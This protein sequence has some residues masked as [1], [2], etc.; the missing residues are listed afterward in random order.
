MNR[1]RKL[2]NKMADT[3]RKVF[4]DAKKN[5]AELY[6][7]GVLFVAVPAAV[8]LLTSAEWGLLLS[9]VSQ[10]VVGLLYIRGKE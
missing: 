9:F 6:T 3:F 1:L 8:A 5:I 7:M 4:L 2:K 10:A